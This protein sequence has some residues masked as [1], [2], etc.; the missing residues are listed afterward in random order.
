[1]KRST[2]PFLGSAGT[3]ILMMAGIASGSVALILTA[4]GWSFKPYDPA[5][6]PEPVCPIGYEF[7]NGECVLVTP[8]ITCPDGFHLEGESCAPDVVPTCPEGYLYSEG[9]CVPPEPE[10]VPEP[11]PEPT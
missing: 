10:P 3:T 4:G 2:G 1:M 6:P 5:G 7:Q 8:P 9:E 11:D